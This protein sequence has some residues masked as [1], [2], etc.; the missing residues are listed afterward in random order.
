MWVVGVLGSVILLGKKYLYKLG[1]GGVIVRE[2]KSKYEEINKCGDM[3]DLVAYMFAVYIPADTERSKVCN[4]IANSISLDWKKD[5]RVQEQAMCA[6][7]MY[8]HYGVDIDT[9]IEYGRKGEAI[10]MCYDYYSKDKTK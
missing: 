5:E 7:T 3:A 1:N 10:T 2:E 6:V 4:L 8:Y 9:V